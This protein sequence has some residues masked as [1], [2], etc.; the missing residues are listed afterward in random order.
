LNHDLSFVR[1]WE[2]NTVK[3]LMQASSFFN[4]RL[5]M[6]SGIEILNGLLQMLSDAILVREQVLLVE[7]ALASGSIIL[8]DVD[9]R[10]DPIAHDFEFLRRRDSIILFETVHVNKS[11]SVI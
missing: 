7:V 1:I 8:T 9:H 2:V 3:N 5:I 10:N 11:E 6:H 4:F